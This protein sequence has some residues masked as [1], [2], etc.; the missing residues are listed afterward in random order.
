M[1]MNILVG[2]YDRS[3]IREMLKECSKM[4]KFEHK[5]VLTLRGVCLDGGPAPYI[6]MPF[7]ANGSLLAYLRKNRSTL[8][9]SCKEQS[10]VATF[11]SA[12]THLC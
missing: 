12:C 10:E 3:T 7:M 4:H 5:N 6:V 11:I 2:F 9:V 8:A 1:H